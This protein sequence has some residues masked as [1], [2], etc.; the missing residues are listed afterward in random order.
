MLTKQSMGH[1]RNQRGNKYL[2][3]IENSNNIPNSLG[4]TQSSS[5]KQ[6]YSNTVQTQE[7]KRISI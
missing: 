1:W 4:H 2:K 5:K 6:G 7:T 3:T